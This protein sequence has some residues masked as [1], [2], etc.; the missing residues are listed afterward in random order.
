M[1][2]INDIDII[3]TDSEAT[4]TVVGAGTAFPIIFSMAGQEMQ[5][6]DG[7]VMTSE[8][9]AVIKSAAVAANSIDNGIAVTITDPVNALTAAAYTVLSVKPDGMGLSVVTLLTT[10]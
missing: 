9:F 1:S 10:H 5:M 7:S 6:F 2:I 8:P 4:M 3:F